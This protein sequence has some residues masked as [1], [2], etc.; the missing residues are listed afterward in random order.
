VDRT[1]AMWRLI[2]RQTGTAPEN[3]QKLELRI[4]NKIISN[5]V[6]ITDKLNSHF[7]S[8]VEEFVKQKSSGSVYNFKIN[9]CPNPV[10]QEVFS[11]TKSLKVKPTP[12]DDDIIDNLVKQ[13]IHLI[14]RPLTHI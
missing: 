6:E 4:G 5:P 10:T 1:K 11:L 13:C 8:T 2:N 12:G 3:E 14:K 7:I 9:H